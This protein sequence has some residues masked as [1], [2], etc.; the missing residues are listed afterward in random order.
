[1]GCQNFPILTYSGPL[2]WSDA[3]I[4]SENGREKKKEPAAAVMNE[5][6]TPYGLFYLRKWD[7]SPSKRRESQHGRGKETYFVF[8]RL[9]TK[10]FSLCFFFVYVLNMYSGA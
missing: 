2:F 7:S 10:H 3:S 8:I 9:F 6:L 5:S 1:M 4:K